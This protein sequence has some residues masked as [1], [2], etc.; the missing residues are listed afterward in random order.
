[1]AVEVCPKTTLLRLSGYFVA[2]FLSSGSETGTFRV[3][4][5]PLGFPTSRHVLNLVAGY[6]AATMKCLLYAY[7][8]LEK[9]SNNGSKA[10]LKPGLESARGQ[11]GHGPIIT[12]T[13]PPSKN[14]SKCFEQS[15]WIGRAAFGCFASIL[16]LRVPLTAP[17]LG[18]FSH[19]FVLPIRDSD[20]MTEVEA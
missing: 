1:M 8:R 17:I 20:L 13:P 3:S 4:P 6:P 14:A 9:G 12:S 7:P 18:P 11:L 19:F 15:D 10:G 2:R 5:K 16:D